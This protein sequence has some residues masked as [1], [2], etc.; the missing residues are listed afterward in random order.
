LTI[1]PT[2]ACGEYILQLYKKLDDYQAGISYGVAY[3]QQR[4]RVVARVEEAV[5]NGAATGGLQAVFSTSGAAISLDAMPR[6]SNRCFRVHW[7]K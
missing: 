3:V 7:A 1:A 5:A 4:R 2:C 6:L